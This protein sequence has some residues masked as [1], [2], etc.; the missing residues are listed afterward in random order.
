MP[1]LKG[2]RH[3]YFWHIV[4]ALILSFQGM[5][6]P[7]AYLVLSFLPSDGLEVNQRVFVRC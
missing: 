6:F 3:S 4:E 5:F 2:E 1:F 7:F